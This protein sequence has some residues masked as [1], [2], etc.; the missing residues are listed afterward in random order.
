MHDFAI[1]SPNCVDSDDFLKSDCGSQPWAYFLFLSFNIISMY[2][3]TGILVAV[4][5]DNFAYVYQIAAN[6]SLVN[7]EEIRKFKNAWAEIDV[8]RTGYIQQKDYVRFWQ[9]RQR[10]MRNKACNILD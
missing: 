8:D 9:V 6:F 2:I 10:N 7:R 3:F 1:E 5:S 4:V